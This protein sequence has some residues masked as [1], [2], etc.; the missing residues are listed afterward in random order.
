MVGREPTA[1]ERATADALW[2]A[3]LS[4]PKG[5][6]V[7]AFTALSAATGAGKTTSACALMAYLAVIDGLPCAYVVST[8]AVAEEVHQHLVRLMK[9]VTMREV[10]SDTDGFLPVAAYSSVHRANASPRILDEYAEQGVTPSAQ[11]NEEQFRQAQ[12][13]VTT[14]ERWR[15]EMATGMDLGVLRCS[16]RDR[17][18]VVVDEEP[19]LD[20]SIVRQPEDVSA[21]ASLLADVQLKGEARSYGFTTAHPAAAALLAI[22]ER[23]RGVKDNAT[24]H[25]LRSAEVVTA[26]DLADLE[27]ISQRD[28]VARVSA[29]GVVDRTETLDY[30]RGTVEFLKL[31]AQGR[32]FYSRDEGGAFYAY[33]FP[34]APRARHLILDG[35][36]D[37]N[38]MYAV[39]KHV[40]VVSA[41]AANYERVKLNAVL[42]PT[43]FRGRMRR[44]GILRNDRAVHD[45]FSWFIPFLLERTHSGQHVLVYCKKQMLAYGVHKVPQFDDSGDRR[46]RYVS[47]Q[48]GRTIHWCSF[49]RGRGLNQWKNCT[50]Y[51]RLG[52]FMLK[53]AVVLSRIGA[54]TGEHFS[55]ADLRRFNSGALKDARIARAQAAHL[56][57][58][59]KQDAARICIRHLDDDG[60]AAAAELY[61]VDCDLAALQSYR[62]RMFPGAGAYTVLSLEDG[63]GAAGGGSG[64]TPRDGAASRVAQLLLTTSLHQLTVGDL[65]AQCGLRPDNYARTVSTAEVQEAMSA[66][67]W[68]ETTRRALGLPGKGKMLVRSGAD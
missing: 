56:A 24:G 65:A 62:V 57:T 3:Y 49:G 26:A 1:F 15:H 19:E 39:G 20:H 64:G 33:G 9:P 36:A 41:V 23:M 45:Y 2:S 48:H 17:A 63:L 67:G 27:G 16:G 30:H 37:L 31:A 58:T 14:H 44:G 42:P 52:D 60:R 40:S 38:G 25:F 7:H 13:V 50:A 59:N 28:I 22:H 47:T 5:G 32:V 29:L 10:P 6:E 12:L 35:T 61:M 21:L 46:T 55:A 68:F 18:L 11:Y 34:V 51:F 43:Q 66:R 53:R 8:I 54:T 4:M